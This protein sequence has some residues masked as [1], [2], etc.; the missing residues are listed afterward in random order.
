MVV[1]FSILIYGFYLITKLI[2]LRDTTITTIITIITKIITKIIT[3]A[4]IT[5]LKQETKH[6]WMQYRYV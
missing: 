1:F 3:T 6:Y 2:V 5:I 4:A